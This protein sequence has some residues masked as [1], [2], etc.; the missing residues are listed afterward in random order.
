MKYVDPNF[1]LLAKGIVIQGV[2][3]YKTA[4]KQKWALEQKMISI[5]K[6]L[7]DCESFFLSEW[8]AELSD[9]DDP[10]YI[11][12]NAFIEAKKEYKKEDATV[13]II[14][15]PKETKKKGDK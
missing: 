14:I 13:N 2:E 12:N 6:S 4:L 11:K 8:C 10:S 3:D 15:K 1:D 5:N 7:L 9:I